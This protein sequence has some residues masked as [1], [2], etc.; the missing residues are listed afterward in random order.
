MRLLRLYWGIP[1]KTLKLLLLES[2]LKT[3]LCILNLWVSLKRKDVASESE[4][5]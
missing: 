4:R 3:Q 2:I 5:S 1:R